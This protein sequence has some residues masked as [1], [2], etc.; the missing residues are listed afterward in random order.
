MVQIANFLNWLIET[1]DQHEGMVAML[2]IAVTV[3]IFMREVSNNYFTMEQDNFK[4]IFKDLALKQ[5]PEK[6]DGVELAKEDEWSDRFKELMDVLD[7]MLVQSKYYKYSIPFFYECLRLRID[8]IRDL[9]RHDNWR[10]YRSGVKQN[11]L[12]QI[13]CSAIIR[14]INDA[15]KGRVFSIKVYQNKLV[16]K[17]RHLIIKNLYDHP[18]D[19]ITETYTEASNDMF[20]FSTNDGDLIQNNTL[21]KLSA[22]NVIIKPNS[23]KKIRIV[24]AKGVNRGEVYF[25][26]V[27]NIRW[28]RYIGKIQIKA[29][30]DRTVQIKHNR[31][32]NQVHIKLKDANLHK[33]VIMWMEDNDLNHVYFAKFNVRK[34]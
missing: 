19:R 13:K 33:I 28:G 26:Y 27:G 11:A 18:A 14:N 17:T 31:N 7:E 6:I 9:E 3:I 29:G 10:L 2:G 24:E 15:S 5:L 8:E 25:G 1:M 20:L 30:E 34:K 23:S 4:D 21:K 12:I 32:Q 22:D 16:Q